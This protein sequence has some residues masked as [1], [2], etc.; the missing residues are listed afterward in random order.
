[1]TGGNTPNL[2]LKRIQGHF[3]KIPPLNKINLKNEKKNTKLIQ[4]GYFEFKIEPILENLKD[5]L[6]RLE[7]KIQ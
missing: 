6:Y 4:N 7:K 5:K 1:M 3:V 2:V